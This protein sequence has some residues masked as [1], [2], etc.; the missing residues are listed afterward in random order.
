MGGVALQFFRSPTFCLV[1][2]TMFM[3]IE[4]V[5]A[6]VRVCSTLIL[7]YLMRIRR[8]TGTVLEL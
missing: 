6:T 2:H 3:L 8:Y 7:F 4:R 1:K 5:L